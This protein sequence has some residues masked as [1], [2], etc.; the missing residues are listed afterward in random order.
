MF[1]GGLDARFCRYM[2]SVLGFGFGVL[3][4]FL[5]VL[6]AGTMGLGVPGVVAFWVLDLVFCIALVYLLT[7]AGL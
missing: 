7:V 5:F 6:S 1:C 4:C 2:F 3:C